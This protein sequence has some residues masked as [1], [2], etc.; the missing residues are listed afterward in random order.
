MV[1][2]KELHSKCVVAEIDELLLG[3]DVGEQGCDEGE[4]LVSQTN[5]G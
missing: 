5:I 2:Q 4:D 3:V 1:L